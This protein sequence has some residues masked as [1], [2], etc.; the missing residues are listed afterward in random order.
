MSSV[1]RVAELSK[2]E[3]FELYINNYNKNIKFT[4]AFLT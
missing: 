2:R 3:G 1:E 4:L